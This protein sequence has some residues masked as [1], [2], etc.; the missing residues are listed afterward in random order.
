M[1]PINVSVRSYRI[2]NSNLRVNIRNSIR[3]NLARI[4]NNI[5]PLQTIADLLKIR[6]PYKNIW[7]GVFDLKITLAA[8]VIRVDQILTSSLSKSQQYN[9]YGD[10]LNFLTPN[11][12]EVS[13]RLLTGKFMLFNETGNLT[14][15]VN[16]IN[17]PL[18]Q[19][20]MDWTSKRN[21]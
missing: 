19:I 4:H 17:I 10:Q 16:S 5:S 7:A 12:F 11:I 3:N 21:I 13:E 2:A 9:I 8:T 15:Y 20:L 14:L 6:A 18:K 1:K